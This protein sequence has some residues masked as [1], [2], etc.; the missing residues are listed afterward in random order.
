MRTDRFQL[1]WGLLA[2]VGLALGCGGPTGAVA[3]AAQP[4]ATASAALNYG[5]YSLLQEDQDP[6]PKGSR[7]RVRYCASWQCA[8]AADKRWCMRRCVFSWDL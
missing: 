4:P 2:L 7:Q 5:G 3:P 8:F 6:G 1:R